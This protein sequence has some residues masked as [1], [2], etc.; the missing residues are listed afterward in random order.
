MRFRT[1]RDVDVKTPLGAV[2]A[3]ID[4][5]NTVVFSRK[6]SFIRNDMTGEEIEMKRKG[7]TY[8][9]ELNAAEGTGGR[10]GNRMAVDG[11][12]VDTE[13]DEQLENMIKQRY[14]TERWFSGGRCRE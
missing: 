1:Q 6:R 3:I 12:D 11:I 5:D 4:E 8:V 13:A 7:G 9:I 10:M 2:I 14:G